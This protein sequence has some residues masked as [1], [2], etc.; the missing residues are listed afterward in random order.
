MK[1]FLSEHFGESELQTESGRVGVG[2]SGSVQ[3]N[4]QGS[5]PSR[6]RGDSCQPAGTLPFTMYP[7]M[8][9]HA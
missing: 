1:Y 2:A 4:L 6:F 9:F 5:Y 8:A 7:G 3:L